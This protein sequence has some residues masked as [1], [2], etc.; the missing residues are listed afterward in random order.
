MRVV[1]SRPPGRPATGVVAG[2]LATLVVAPAPA[3]AQ[4]CRP[5]DTRALV[6]VGLILSPLASGAH[7]RGVEVALGGTY[8]A[9]G[10]ELT[11]SVFSTAPDQGRVRPLGVR[12]R[13]ERPLV[14][15][16]GVTL[17]GG[18]LAGGSTI[19]DGEDGARTVAGGAGVGVTRR[20]SAGRLTVAPWL[21]G[22]ALGARTAGEVLGESFVTTGLSLGLEAGV[23][24]STGRATGALRLTADGFDAGLGATPYPALAVRLVAGWRL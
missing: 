8:A 22:R 5:G 20:L 21:G 9:G 18:V 23:G 12:L 11:G 1:T 3:A 10:T 7:A 15:V 14:D 4:E 17:C 16:A 19:R 6:S 2:L 24:V 13:L